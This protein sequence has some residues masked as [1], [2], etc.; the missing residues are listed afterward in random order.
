MPS[1]HGSR[2]SQVKD[3]RS[4]IEKIVDIVDYLQYSQRG[5]ILSAQDIFDATRVDVQGVDREVLDNLYG[6]PKIDITDENGMLHFQYR[7]KFELR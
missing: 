6:N 3:T 2:Q 7:A 4:T 5:Q 1:L